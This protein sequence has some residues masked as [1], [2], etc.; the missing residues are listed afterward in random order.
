MLGAWPLLSL[1]R[2]LG[3]A[4]GIQHRQERAPAGRQRPLLGCARGAQALG[5][6]VAHRLLADGH[7]GPHVQ[8]RPHRRASP[9]GVR[10]F[11]P[12]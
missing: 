7:E 2:L 8:G 12:G 5:K 1:P 4:Q 10:V 6:G 3:L 11:T 9:Q